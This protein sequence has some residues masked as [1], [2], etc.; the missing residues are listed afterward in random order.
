VYK[1]LKDE[2]YYIDRYDLHTIETCLD[3][4][5]GIKKKLKK[6]KATEEFK[7]LNEKEFDREANKTASCVV[8]MIKAKR[9]ERKKDV[10]QGWKEKDEK[11]QEKFDNA[12]A[13]QG[14][15]CKECF[16]PTRVI[17]KELDNLPKEGSKVLFFFECTKCKK[18]QAIYEDGTEHHHEKIKCPECSYTLNE[19]STYT[20]DILT[21]IYSCPN[22]SYKSKETYDF[23]ESEK[24]SR[25]REARERKLLEEY[26]EE[27]CVD[28]ETGE[29]IL[30]FFELVSNI[31]KELDEKR[32]KD[33]DPLIQQARKLKKLTVAQLRK[34]IVEDLEKEGY[35]DMKFGK[36]E[37]G[38]YVIVDFSVLETKDDMEEY[39]SQRILKKL[40][41]KLLK[42]TNWRLMSDGISYRLGI[43]TG[44]LKAYERE[45][46]LVE[47][48]KKRKK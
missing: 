47:I 27:F 10:I 32:R 33:K 42:D 6:E 30:N 36:P 24:E 25:N 38:K 26:R 37:I 35:T 8:N 22:C 5:N 15:L 20:K 18:R 13:P 2:Q 14:V 29:R 44:R 45:E 17:L 39:D 28:D 48:L 11:D 16:S 43:L 12:V 9:Y 21:T 23:S 7:K 46:D 19:K 31:G 40:I 34:L 3:Y 41:S 4:Y 1:Y